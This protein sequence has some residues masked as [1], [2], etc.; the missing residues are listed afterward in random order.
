MSGPD[1]ATRADGHD[2]AAR[3]RVSVLHVMSPW[4]RVVDAEILWPAVNAE[5]AVAALY[6]RE[7]AK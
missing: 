2:A 6:N 5:S 4:W 7:G 1:V 3:E